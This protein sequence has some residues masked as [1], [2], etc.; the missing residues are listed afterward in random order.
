VSEIERWKRRRAYECPACG[1]LHA[2]G[3]GECPLVRSPN[4]VRLGRR[5]APTSP[6]VRAENERLR[7]AGEKL[8]GAVLGLDS[9]AAL[10]GAPLERSARDEMRSRHGTSRTPVRAGAGGAVPCSRSR[11]GGSGRA[12]AGGCVRR[13]TGCVAANEPARGTA[14]VVHGPV[15]HGRDARHPRAD[16]RRGRRPVVGAADAG[17]AAGGR[18]ADRR[19]VR[20]RAE[21][22]WPALS[23]RLG[24]MIAR[25]SRSD[26]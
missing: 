26:L 18:D 20:E 5:R 1:A 4:C 7:E 23:T 14:R 25:R 16:S 3:D 15:R 12:V 10:G 22:P 8:V 21:E 11:D 24:T 13:L 6:D 17:P 19:S 9:Y 2:S